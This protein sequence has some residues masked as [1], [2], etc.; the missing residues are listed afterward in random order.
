LKLLAGALGAFAVMGTNA[1]AFA[2]P[3][4]SPP[5]P[6]LIDQMVSSSSALSVNPTDDGS[7]TSPWGGVGMFCQNFGIRCR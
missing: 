3:E 6:S 2:Q 4:P 1:S 7:E 5:L